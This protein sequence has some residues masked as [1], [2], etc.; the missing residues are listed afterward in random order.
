[1]V[2]AQL[3]RQAR[4]RARLTQGE[5]ASR[6]GTTQSA[7]SRWE[8]GRT[9]PSAETLQKLIRACG[10]E[11]RFGIAQRDDDRDSQIEGN[12][13][14][15]PTQRLDQLVR[16]ARFVSAGRQRLTRRGG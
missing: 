1:M 4:L 13:R 5:L 3:I 8:G 2:S 11:L 6:A 7:L 12:L 15:T 10:L 16:T 9:E 14:L